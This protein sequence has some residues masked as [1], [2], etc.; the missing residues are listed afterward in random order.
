MLDEA[1]PTRL[2]HTRELGDIGFELCL[3]MWTKTSKAQ[4]PSIEPLSSSPFPT[5]KVAWGAVVETAL[6][7]PDSRDTAG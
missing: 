2:Q 3:L 1:Q 4:T 5:S 7:F 6:A